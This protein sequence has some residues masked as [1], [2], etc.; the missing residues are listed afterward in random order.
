MPT[1]NDVQTWRGQDVIGPDGEKVGTLEHVYLDRESGEPTFAA[2]KTGLFG[3]RHNLVPIDGFR[4]SAEGLE[5]SF[6]KATI[7]DAPNIDADQELTP[8]EEQQLYSHYGRT[9]AAYDGEDRSAAHGGYGDDQRGPAGQDTSGP[10]TD[11]A[12][13]R[14]EEELAVGTTRRE[15]GRARLRKYVA[16]NEEV[17]EERLDAEGEVKGRGV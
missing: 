5:V 1:L 15:V 2:V 7:K 12:M 13:T 9:Y 17:R 3:L 6:D 11:S 16:I 14:S 8:E 10:G 4:H